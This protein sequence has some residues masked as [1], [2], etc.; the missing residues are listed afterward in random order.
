MSLIGYV[1]IRM[2]Y[3][4]DELSMYANE[5]LACVYH[6][7]EWVCVSFGVGMDWSTRTGYGPRHTKDDKYGME[8]S[9]LVMWATHRTISESNSGIS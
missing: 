3:V 7:C 2:V 9:T 6:L 8:W 1:K 4:R 5:T